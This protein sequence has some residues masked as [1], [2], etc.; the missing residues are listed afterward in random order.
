[1][2]RTGQRTDMKFFETRQIRDIDAATIANEPIAS[3]D[4]MERAASRLTEAVAARYGHGGHLFAIFAGPGNNGGDA[5]AMARMLADGGE[6]VAVWLVAPHGK[7]SPDCR[8]NLERLEGYD[9]HVTVCDT[10][11]ETPL[12]PSSAVIVDGLFGSGLSRPVDGVFAEVIRFVNGCEAATV[13]IDI[14]SGLHGEMLWDAGSENI[15]SADLTLTLQFPKLSFLFP[16]NEKWVGRWQVVDIGL[17]RMAIDAQPTKYHFTEFEDIKTHIQPRKI[18]SH[19]GDYG[20]ALLVAGSLGM[21]GASALSARAALRSGV[22]LLTLFIPRCNNA[23]VQTSVPEA[24]TQPC[25]GETHL[26]AAPSTAAF[27][28]VG[29]GPGLGTHP[30]T[31]EALLGLIGQS[32]RP[33]VLDADALNILAMNPEYMQKIPSGS[34]ITPHP[35]EFA[36]LAGAGNSYQQLQKAMDMARR[37]TLCVVLKGAYT[38]VCSPDGSCHFNSTGNPGMATGGSGDVLTGVVLALL[39]RGYAAADA[40]RIAVY[41]HGLAGDIAAER[42]GQTALTAGDI[43]DALPSAWK[44]MEEAVIASS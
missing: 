32:S 26:A 17:S 6:D 9:I 43:V 2:Q 35:G 39:A 12:L 37:Y 5:L 30:E 25:N 8:Q 23:I 20:R 22:G 18:F 3:I 44:K 40:A 42:Y 19:K 34:V 11:F 1:M 15:V 28:A 27:N 14:P 33:M 24:M 4:L 16:E 10:H 31:A 38:A 21:A 36:R 29:V 13:A 41:V 7:L